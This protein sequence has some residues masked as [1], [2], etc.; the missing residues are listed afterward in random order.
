MPTA[1]SFA[2][3]G[4]GNG[5]PFCASKIDV[6]G[7]DNWIT[8]GGTAKGNDPTDGEKTTSL[9]NAMKLWWNYYSATGSFSASFS[10]PDESGSVTHTGKEVIIKRDGEGGA[11][12]PVNRSCKGTD[13]SPFRND[14]LSSGFSDEDIVADN[15]AAGSIGAGSFQFI[16]RMYNGTTS[17]ESNFVG[18]G[19][20]RLCISSVRAF[21][22]GGSSSVSVE[23]TVGSFLDETNFTGPDPN[24]SNTF[25]D[26]KVFQTNLNGI[27]FRSK[28]Y[29]SAG[30]PGESGSGTSF[31]VSASELSGT[32]QASFTSSSGNSYS[33]AAS[34]SISSI[35]FYTYS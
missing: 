29:C 3:L 6:S 31:S 8:L 30:S 13:P 10:T 2:A 32:A 5:F 19:V 28:T 33:S 15:G 26:I 16:R 7:Y 24:V 34:A 1:T 18:Y 27:P 11:L 14:Q 20:S 21:T 12:E 4:K 35:D 9:E 25:L 17:D 23:I 22:I